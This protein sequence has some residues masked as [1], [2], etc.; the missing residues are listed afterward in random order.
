MPGVMLAV[1]LHGLRMLEML[2]MLELVRMLKSDAGNA[3]D[4]EVVG[5]SPCFH[6]LGQ[7]FIGVALCFT[8]SSILCA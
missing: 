6:L 8:H 1:A 4:G 2:F 3:R 5:S 7:P